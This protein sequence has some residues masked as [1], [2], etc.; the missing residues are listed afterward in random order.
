MFTRVRLFFLIE[1]NKAQFYMQMLFYSETDYLNS[2]RIEY[3][4]EILLCYRG[5][6]L[7]IKN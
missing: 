4:H 5:K 1:T 3:I 7:Q 6:V 2:K